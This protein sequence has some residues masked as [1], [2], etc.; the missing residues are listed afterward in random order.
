[1]NYGTVPDEAESTVVA[2]VSSA[3]DLSGKITK[4]IHGG[5]DL[6]AI[7]QTLAACSRHS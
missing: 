4:A 3:T 5:G 1:M 2:S 7:L 6:H